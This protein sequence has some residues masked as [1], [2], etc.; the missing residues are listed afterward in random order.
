MFSS[1]IAI[2]SRELLRVSKCAALM[3]LCS[4]PVQAQ[5]P[6]NMSVPEIVNI[7]LIGYLGTWQPHRGT[8]DVTLGYGTKIYHLQLQRLRVL[9]GEEDPSDILTDVAPYYPNFILQG[10]E[11]ELRQLDWAKPGEHIEITGTIRV[12]PQQLRIMDIKIRPQV[13]ADTS[14]LSGAMITTPIALAGSGS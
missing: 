5:W 14:S 8:T 10:P 12:G 3:M 4:G 9:A 1:W 2:R 11:D 7:R 13:G 6:V